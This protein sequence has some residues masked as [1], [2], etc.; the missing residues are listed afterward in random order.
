[1]SWNTWKRNSEKLQ[2]ASFLIADR[3]IETLSLGDRGDFRFFAEE[4]FRH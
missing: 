1:L 4:E 3:T 2:L